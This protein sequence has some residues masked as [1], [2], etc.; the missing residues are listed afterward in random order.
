MLTPTTFPLPI[1]STAIAATK[2]ESTPPDRAMTAFS[3][4]VLRT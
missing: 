3:N 4:P 1:A 2:L